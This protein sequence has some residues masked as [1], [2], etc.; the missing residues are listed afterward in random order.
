M[1]KSH[2]LV[3][4][5]SMFLLASCGED[6]VVPDEETVVQGVVC[7]PTSLDLTVGE[8][9][10]VVN[11]RVN[12]TGNPSQE[13][14]LKSENEGIATVAPLEDGSTSF[15]VSPVSA[16][17]TVITVTSVAD[18]SKAASVSV[19]VNPAK[20]IEV[21]PEIFGIN[22]DTEGFELALASA[23]REVR[24]V[25]RGTENIDKSFTIVADNENVVLNKNEVTQPADLVSDTLEGSFTVSA[26]AVG[27]TT[28]QVTSIADKKYSLSIPVR[29]SDG[30]VLP[31]EDSVIFD[32]FVKTIAPEEAFDIAVTSS[33]PVIYSTDPVDA[34][35]VF[36]YKVTDN[37]VHVVG[38]GEG[39]AKLYGTVGSEVAVCDITVAAVPTDVRTIY[40]T[41]NAA[42]GFD[43]MYLHAW[44]DYGETLGDWPGVKL[45]EAYKN[46]RSEDCYR[47]TLDIYKYPNFILNNGKSGDEEKKTPDC[48]FFTENDYDNIWFSNNDGVLVANKAT[49]TPYG[50]NV[51]FEA[52]D[53][54]MYEGRTMSIAVTSMLGDVQYS[55]EEG[56][57]YITILEHDNSHVEIR[58]EYAGNA[59][60]KAMI[61][62]HDSYE[63]VSDTI[64]ITVK[65]SS[66]IKTYYFSNNQGWDNVYFHS[67]GGTDQKPAWPGVKLTDKVKNKEGED[68]YTIDINPADYDG[69]LFHNNDGVQTVDITFTDVG[70][71]NNIYPSGWNEGEGKFNVGFATYSPYIYEVAFNQAGG[72][73]YNN[74]DL[75]LSVTANEKVAFSIASGSEFV[76][77]N[78]ATDNFVKLGFVAAGSATIKATCGDAVDTVDITVVNEPAPSANKMIYFS[79]S[80]GWDSVS[81]YAFG[82]GNAENAVWPGVNVV[83]C[84]VNNHDQDLYAFNLDANVY[85][86][87]IV[88]DGKAEGAKQTV[89]ISFAELGTDDNVWANEETDGE[90]HYTVGHTSLAHFV[91]LS[92]ETVSIYEGETKDIS[93]KTTDMNLIAYE[94]VTGSADI[95]KL[96]TY[97]GGFKLTYVAE[98]TASIKVSCGAAEATISITCT[99]GEKPTN[100]ETYYFTNNYYWS[101]VRAYVF[102]D[103]GVSP[104]GWPGDSLTS[105]G[106]NPQGEDVYKVEID[107]N[108]Y[109]TFVINGMDSGKGKT[110]KTVDINMDSFK[111]GNNA[112]YISGWDD[113]PGLVASVDYWKLIPSVNFDFVEEGVQVGGK[114]NVELVTI[115]CSGVE[116]SSNT[117]GVATVDKVDDNHATVNGV[118]KGDAVITAKATVNGVD[119]Q[120]SFIIHVTEEEPAHIHHYD[121]TTHYCSCGELD[122]DY[123]KVSFTALGCN[124]NLG[125]DIYIC[126]SMC[127]WSTDNAIALSYSGGDWVGDV[128]LKIGTTYEYKLIKKNG[129]SVTW[130]RSGEG[131]TNR[132][133][134]P[135]STTT[136]VTIHWDWWLE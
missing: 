112:I 97:K 118:S 52:E 132:T 39:K 93:I 7:G 18:E 114:L 79:N 46:D 33:G 107:T 66:N 6:F 116:F 77:I 73:V 103:G 4:F 121:A 45:T 51:K 127:G 89:N 26:N 64:N 86:A 104:S 20:I 70:T 19:H 68:C 47:Y 15:K 128:V 75:T 37:V 130:E 102:G 100:I 119:Y 136:S 34:S 81:V 123:V 1:K 13:V 129:S 113:E 32:P 126:G 8:K 88:N 72:I 108:V 134:T 92:K 71:D 11:Y 96:E 98:G 101:D 24:V 69:F 91:E 131:A 110:A 67:W 120:D 117:P 94:Y 12:G 78:S 125:E 63:E 82:D 53:L 83:K 10:G 35:A 5:A 95:V 61:P 44:N 41:N 21:T 135:T 29:I 43:E 122:P 31:P 106:K 9:A 22:A 17:D 3:A 23:P 85:D 55:V 38:I 90:G 28:I 65:D 48:V 80:L 27:T 133:L 2:L 87:F 84:G 62:A 54:S 115:Y 76:K 14:T 49:F 50:P 16:G 42:L 57:E 59:V 25:V 109:H 60:L 36:T 58:G 74:K 40:F 99:A 124:T 30:G 111:D 56:S 105:V